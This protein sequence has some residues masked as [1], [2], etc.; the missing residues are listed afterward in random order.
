MTDWGAVPTDRWDHLLS[1]VHVI[2]SAL[3]QHI[4][5]TQF[6]DAL[7]GGVN[8]VSTTRDL[9][10]VG[11]HFEPSAEGAI[12]FEF[13]TAGYRL[14]NYV[15]GHMEMRY[16]FILWRIKGSWPICDP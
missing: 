11:D 7:L 14:H 16:V 12:S 8:D 5:Y 13:G 1:S 10:A 15:G 9:P 3:V 4:T 2:V 6:L